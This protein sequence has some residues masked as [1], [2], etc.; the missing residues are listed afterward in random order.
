MKKLVFMFLLLCSALTLL[1]HAAILE[2]ESFEG[3]TFPPAG[4]AAGDARH[5]LG[6]EAVAAEQ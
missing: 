1:T 5:M 3:E 4:W 2:E 6:T